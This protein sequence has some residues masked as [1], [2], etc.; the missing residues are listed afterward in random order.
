MQSNQNKIIDF[1]LKKRTYKLKKLPEFKLL[2]FNFENILKDISFFQKNTKIIKKSD[3]LFDKM[4]RNTRD[5][6]KSIAIQQNF[7]EEFKRMG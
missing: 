7:V 6:P 3:I 2:K 1:N 5:Y 4:I